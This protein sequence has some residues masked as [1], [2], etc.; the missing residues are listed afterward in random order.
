M[1]EVAHGETEVVHGMAVTRYS[2]VTKMAA[3]HGLQPRADFRNGVVPAA[4]AAVDTGESIVSDVL[5]MGASAL[6]VP[7]V[8]TSQ[9]NNDPAEQ[10]YLQ[11]LQN[12]A[13][14]HQAEPEPQTST[15]GAGKGVQGGKKDR[16]LQGTLD[17]LTDIT[18]N[19]KQL[20]NDL[21]LRTRR[22]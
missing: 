16:S 19:Q 5:G 10:K 15:S 8:L 14:E 13:E 20:R 21:A 6:A 7:F 9:A 3:Y 12:Q 11:S 4:T 22:S 17:N 2:E 1:P 18:E